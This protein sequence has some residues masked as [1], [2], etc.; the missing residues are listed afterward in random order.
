VIDAKSIY[1]G[2]NGKPLMEAVKANLKTLK[3]CPCHKFLLDNTNWKLNNRVKCKECGGE[4]SIYDARTWT[5]G[6]VAGLTH[7]QEI[8]R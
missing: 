1:E 5:D 7:G 4:M 2:L 6:Y 8:A 3:D